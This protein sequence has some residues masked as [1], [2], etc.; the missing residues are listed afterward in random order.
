MGRR[1]RAP[2][3]CAPRNGERSSFAFALT[4]PTIRHRPEFP[5]QTRDFILAQIPRHARLHRHPPPARG[6]FSRSFCQLLLWFRRILITGFFSVCSQLWREKNASSG[7]LFSRCSQLWEFVRWLDIKSPG[8]L[9]AVGLGGCAS[10]V[11]SCCARGAARRKI[12]PRV[13]RES[14]PCRSRPEPARRESP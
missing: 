7:P 6:L 1:I 10:S 12:E 11:P 3:R 8:N 13:A 4:L 14:C 9:W 5:S 2:Q